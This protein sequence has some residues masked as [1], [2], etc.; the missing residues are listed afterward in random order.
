MLGVEADRVAGGACTRRGDPVIAIRGGRR[1]PDL[2]DA[3]AAAEERLHVVGR[4]EIR[5]GHDGPG[6]GAQ[7]TGGE[8]VDPLHGLV[9]GALRQ[10]GLGVAARIAQVAQDHDGVR[11][12]L[13]LPDL[14]LSEVLVRAVVAARDG[15][16]PE[17]V[18]GR[19]VERVPVMARPAVAVAEVH[20]DRGAGHSALDG[21]PG[22]VRGVDLHDLGA[23]GPRD[24]GRV[25]GEGPI[26]VGQAPHG[27]D[28]QRDL[29]HGCRRRRGRRETRRANQ[30]D[31]ERSEYQAKPVIQR[32]VS[33]AASMIGG[34]PVAPT[35]V[36]LAGSC[37]VSFSRLNG[38]K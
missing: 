29:R 22:C 11:R 1:R 32:S 23:G 17:A 26:A 36:G 5:L 18:L 21:R 24:L 31:E 35:L 30:H 14:L 34:C 25:V 3:A 4:P 38:A 27:A 33:L 28:D 2:L 20:D 19:R 10:A 13:E 7:E 9:R 6:S 8:V 16:Q 15:V 37:L 12:E